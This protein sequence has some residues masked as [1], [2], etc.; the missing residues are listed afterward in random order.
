MAGT[1]KVVKIALLFILMIAVLHKVYSQ[2]TGDYVDR[3]NIGVVL[4]N[5]G[6]R[7]IA[8]SMAE[9]VFHFKLPPRHLAVQKDVNCTLFENARVKVTCRNIR[10]LFRTFIRLENEAATQLQH[11]IFNVYDVLRDFRVQRRAQRGFFSEV[12]SELTGLA[13]QGDVDE[14]YDVMSRVEAGVQH[15]ADVWTTGTKSIL[16][17][18]QVQNVRFVH[19]ERLLDLQ[20]Q[21]IM[22]LQTELTDLYMQSQRG[23]A[24]FGKMFERLSDYIFQ[25]AEVANIFNSINLLAVGKLYHLFV[26]HAKLQ[27]SLLYLE[28][29]LN[30]THPDLALLRKE[31]SYYFKNAKF[32]TFRYGSY[33]IILLHVPLTL[34]SMTSPLNLYSVTKLPLPAPTNEIHYTEL[35]F[36]YEAIAY[37]R[38]SE[39][40]LPIRH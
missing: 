35:S 14:L 24:L 8:T 12:L 31:P 40:Y 2:W 15:A 11:N 30:S 36:D 28:H 29:Y 13:T 4:H 37:S 23:S 6:N 33:L 27:N 39:F 38:D 7:W 22:E 34:R 20:K 10:N 3:H 21:S 32:N 25:V 16:S 5:V 1:F 17:A 18:F 19:I 26:S 9:V